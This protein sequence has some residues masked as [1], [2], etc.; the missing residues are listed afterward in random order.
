MSSGSD[1]F[2][3]VLRED[4]TAQT[5]LFFLAL[6]AA[7]LVVAGALYNEDKYIVFSIVP[8]VLFT[9]ELY[10]YINNKQER[11]NKKQGE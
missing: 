5:V 6:L 7:G 10:Y 11:N 3:V 2:L 9:I 4:A 8:L 1:S